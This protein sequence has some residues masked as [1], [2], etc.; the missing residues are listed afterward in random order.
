M[1]L[2]VPKVASRLAWIGL[3]V[4]ALVSPASPASDVTSVYRPALGTSVP[5]PVGWQVGEYQGTEVT[6][7]NP[8]VWALHGPRITI[9]HL[10]DA[11]DVLVRSRCQPPARKQPAFEG[12]TSI[13]GHAGSYQY[14]C[15]PRT[16]IGPEWT[17]LI[18][19]SGRAGTWRLTY[20]GAPSIGG[21]WVSRP[22][23]MVLAAFSP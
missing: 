1:A 11:V 23:G 6:V 2:T 19:A 3:I 13:A 12:P 16:F 8:P 4:L 20:M 15:A 9:E 14:L 10:P 21:G 5:V 7:M 18:P 17:V 22:F